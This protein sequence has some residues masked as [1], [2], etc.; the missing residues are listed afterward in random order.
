LYYY[1]PEGFSPILPDP[2]DNILFFKW[3][4]PATLWVTIVVI[5]L[6]ISLSVIRWHRK[7]VVPIFMCL[8]MYAIAFITWNA[9]AGGDSSRHAYQFQLHY[10]LSLWITLLVS[11][12]TIVSEI[13]PRYTSYFHRFRFL[14]IGLGSV[15]VFVS[16][17]ADILFMTGDE[18]SIGYAQSFG[19]L[20]GMGLV[21]IGIRWLQETA[22]NKQI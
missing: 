1:A 21:G 5:M 13:L 18:F 4:N 22:V 8:L 9:S 19:I 11:I 20:L 12:D 6:G 2:F 10:H 16:L 7:W 14:F 15:V 17:F 3:W